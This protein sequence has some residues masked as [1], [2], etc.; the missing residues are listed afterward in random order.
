MI[1][2]GRGKGQIV[3]VLSKSG[4]VSRAAYETHETF[5]WNSHHGVD[6]PTVL[7]QSAL[8]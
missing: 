4:Y 2:A 5:E 6:L 8:W 7:S 3:L 1:E